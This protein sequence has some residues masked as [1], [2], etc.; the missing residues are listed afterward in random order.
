MEWMVRYPG[1]RDDGLRRDFG[2][3][4]PAHSTRS[5][6]KKGSLKYTG[7]VEFSAIIVSLSTPLARWWI[8]R[9]LNKIISS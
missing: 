3:N 7:D 4:R 1:D 8:R 6:F 9:V 5:T 2:H